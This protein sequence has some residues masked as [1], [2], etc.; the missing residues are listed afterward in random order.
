MKNQIS[1]ITL[2]VDKLNLSRKFYEE[3]FGWEPSK[4][5]KSVIVYYRHGGVSLALY[6]RSSLKELTG[7]ANHSEK[8][9]GVLLS[10]NIG[11][12]NEVD[13]LLLKAKSMGGTILKTSC[14]TTWGTYSGFISDPDGYPFEVVWNPKWNL[15]NESS[16]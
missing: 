8:P 10:I 16:F 1:V 13:T 3:G 5:K 7:T 2:G 12:Q 11:S 4:I 6:D 15:D 14:E 9:N